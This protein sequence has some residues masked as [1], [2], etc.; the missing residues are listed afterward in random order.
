MF[1]DYCMNCDNKNKLAFIHIPRTAGKSVR[2]AFNLGWH[3][4]K[5]N[6]MGTYACAHRRASLVWPENVIDEFDTFSVIRDP[7]SRL[8]SLFHYYAGR[9]DM[10]GPYDQLKK[11]NGNFSDFV[12]DLKNLQISKSRVGAPKRTDVLP[13]NFNACRYFIC[14]DNN[15]V[16]IKNLINFKYLNDDLKRFAEKVN[17]KVSFPLEK[18]RKDLKPYPKLGLKHKNYKEYYNDKLVQEVYDFYKDDVEIFGF[19]FE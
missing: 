11:Y 8:V 15:K 2:Q 6:R 13:D 5:F 14:D 19:T 12:F 3:D 18:H 9:P 1:K 4:K 10:K 7:W 17:I 16:L